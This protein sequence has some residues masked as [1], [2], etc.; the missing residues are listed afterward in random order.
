MLGN[1]DHLVPDELGVPDVLVVV[2]HIVVDHDQRPV[3]VLVASVPLR[4]PTNQR[5]RSLPTAVRDKISDVEAQI[6][7]YSS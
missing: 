1:L 3:S 5:H 7:S 2:V 6:S 4:P